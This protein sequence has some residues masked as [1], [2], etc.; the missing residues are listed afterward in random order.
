MPLNYTAQRHVSIA[1]WVIIKYNRSLNLPDQNAT[2]IL[3]AK[4]YKVNVIIAT[5]FQK[6]NT[7]V[8]VLTTT[9]LVFQNLVPKAKF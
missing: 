9:Y 5:S 3:Q 8:F 1:L 7:E 4:S 2:V 6:Q